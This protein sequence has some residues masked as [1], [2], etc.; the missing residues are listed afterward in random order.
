MSGVDLQ[1]CSGKWAVAEAID[2]GGLGRAP[3]AEPWCPSHAA[4]PRQDNSTAGRAHA[5]GR[6]APTML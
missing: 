6:A 2:G 4:T 5:S 3:V 1:R